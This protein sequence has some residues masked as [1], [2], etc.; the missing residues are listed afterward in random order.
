MASLAASNCKVKAANDVAPPAKPELPEKPVKPGVP[1]KPET[2]EAP[3]APKA[4][5]VPEMPPPN[6]RKNRY[7]RSKYAPPASAACK[8]DVAAESY[9]WDQCIADQKAKGNSDEDA[10]RICGA[11]KNRTAASLSAGSPTA[12]AIESLRQQVEKSNHPQKSK[13]LS[14]LNNTRVLEVSGDKTDWANKILRDV[15]KAFGTSAASLSTPLQNATSAAPANQAL[16]A[17]VA[18][19]NGNLDLSEIDEIENG[20]STV[21]KL[22]AGL[23]HDTVPPA[24]AQGFGA[25]L[26]GALAKYDW[27]GRQFVHPMNAGASNEPAKCSACGQPINRG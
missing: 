9:P 2:P 5:A 15:R 25:F 1:E 21:D 10:A 3:I 14:E 24:V 6:S 12:N 19:M 13:L 7:L 16:S 27:N 8:P 11:I 18:K 23:I 20:R 17:W 26:K 22:V 4:D